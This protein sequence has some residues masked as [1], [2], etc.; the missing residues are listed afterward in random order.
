MIHYKSSV[1]RVMYALFYA[2]PLLLGLLEQKQTVQVV[3]FE[4][5][6]EPYGDGTISAMISLESHEVHIYST[7]VIINANFSGFT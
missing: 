4:R 2:L 6:Y 5:Y 7:T 3:L 1:L